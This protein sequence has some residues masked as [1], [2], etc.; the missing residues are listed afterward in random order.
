[1][2]DLQM[3]GIFCEA[4]RQGEVC[5]PALAL[6][7]VEAQ[8]PAFE[9]L[10]AQEPIVAT[11]T[12]EDM[13]S[14]QAPEDIREQWV[15]VVLPVRN[16]DRAHQ[17]GTVE[18]A[19][20]EAVYALKAAVKHEASDWWYARLM[21]T[22]DNPVGILAKGL[23]FEVADGELTELEEPMT[24]FAFYGKDVDKEGLRNHLGEYA[25]AIMGRG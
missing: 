18:V 7:N 23:A 25:A 1:M 8:R 17:S 5:G 14:G 6:L 13:P 2:P 20:I 21:P 11:F 9:V 10:D 19:P 15:S 4:G 3:E 24:S 12:I 22:F 16:L